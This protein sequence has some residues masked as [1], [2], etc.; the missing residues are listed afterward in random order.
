MIFTAESA[1]P[2]TVV[3]EPDTAVPAA[4]SGQDASTRDR[5]TQAISESG[6]VTAAELAELVGLTPAA[7]RRHLDGLSE[8]GLLT[9]RERHNGPRGRGRPARAYVLSEA[10]H[11]QLRG[12][13]RSLAL[14][15]LG[16]LHAVGGDEA[17][18][19]FARRRVTEMVSRMPDAVTDAQ[20]PMEQRVDALAAALRREG[21]AA[22]S[23][24]VSG[25]TAEGI[26]LCQGH[27]PV[28]DVAA[29]YPQLCEAET[30][31][32]ADL[33][34][35]HVQRLSTQAQGGHACTTF[36]PTPSVGGA[37]DGRGD[38]APGPH[39]PAGTDTGAADHG[40]NRPAT[41]RDSR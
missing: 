8:A 1:R 33:L 4:N 41:E 39:E 28:R 10:G 19:A 25:T 32:F 38:L 22:S 37:T 2:G 5:V 7:V 20:L 13:Y 35:G 17:V 16:H 27:C 18:A 6:P 3:P 36:V 23:R 12:D 40:S 31:A 11:E 14:Q 34:G 26:Q 24:P 21:F 9:E 29:L 15:V 30:D